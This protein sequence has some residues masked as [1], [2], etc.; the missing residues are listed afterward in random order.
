MKSIGQ[1]PAILLIVIGLFIS[2][3]LQA[4]TNYCSNSTARHFIRV[5]V[6]NLGQAQ[7][8]TAMPAQVKITTS[9]LNSAW[10]FVRE[11]QHTSSIGFNFQY[12]NVDLESIDAM[13]NG[14]LHTWDF[15]LEGRLSS[16]GSELFYDITP[17]ISVSSNALKNPELIDADGL[18]LNLGM[19]YKKNISL[20]S[21]WLAGFRSDYRFGRYKVYPVVGVCMQPA[22]DWDL[23]LAVPDF[24]ILKRINRGLSLELFA[25]PVGNQWHVFSKDLTRESDFGYNAIAIGLS[26]QWHISA[27]INVGLVIENQTNRRLSFVLDDN[28]LIEVKAESSTGMILKG[29]V[30][31]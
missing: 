20:E 11:Q 2:Q 31:F 6:G 15:P 8:D 1:M 13:T 30:L 5:E 7:L 29:E 27:S 22:R 18:Q 3:S 21:A 17:A 16:T 24:S 28:T 26:A 25:E 23:Q 4:T 9:A 19:V 12:T 14:H 10:V